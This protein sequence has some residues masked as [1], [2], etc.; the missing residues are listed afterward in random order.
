MAKNKLPD[1]NHF[2]PL[3]LALFLGQ[4][5]LSC[6]PSVERIPIGGTTE[7]EENYSPRSPS[8]SPSYQRFRSSKSNQYTTIY[9]GA[10]G[11]NPTLAAGGKSLAI[12]RPPS[13]QGTITYRA[14]TNHCRVSSTTGAITPVSQGLCTI[15][16][17]FAGNTN[18]LASSWIDIFNINVG[19]RSIVSKKVLPKPVNSIVS[20]SGAS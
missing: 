11:N 1:I 17:R 14:T 15:Q 3:L 12:Q 8:P 5:L 9:S 10:Y 20:Q 13:G 7:T 18:Y 2:M 19:P 4:V 16:A 6:R